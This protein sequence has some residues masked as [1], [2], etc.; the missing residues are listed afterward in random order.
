[1]T[2][3]YFGLVSVCIWMQ[4]IRIEFTATEPPFSRTTR[5]LLVASLAVGTLLAAADIIS[6]GGV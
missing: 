1:M 5:V 4:A 6:R 2:G 3:L